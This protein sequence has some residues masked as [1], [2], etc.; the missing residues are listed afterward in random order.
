MNITYLD[1]SATTKPCKSAVEYVN[2]MLIDNWGNPSSLHTLG[3]DAE[4]EITAARQ[5][6][7][8]FLRCDERE[9][10]FTPS[11][12]I[13]NNI[14]IKGA[15][16]AKRRLGNTIVT[17]EIEHPSVY[18][19][20]SSLEEEG[21]NVIRLKP[22]NGNITVEQ[23]KNAITS[24]TILVSMMMVNNETGAILPVDKVSKIIA[25]A[26]SPALFH[27]DAVQAFGKIPI[28]LKTLGAQLVTVSGHKIHAPKGVA[29]LYISQKTRIAPLIF[30][31]GQERGVCPGTESC[32]IPAMGAAIKEIGSISE[33]YKK[34]DG[35][36]RHLIEQVEKLDRVYV[37]SN[38]DCLPYVVNISVEGIKSETLLHF[39]A[40]QGIYVSSG[41]A[42]SKGKKSRVLLSFGI[43]T[44]RVDSALR[45]SFSR[46]NDESDVDKLIT[47][48]K[49]AVSMF[50][51]GR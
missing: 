35:L 4:K 5:T 10:Y 46:Y 45:I 26:K 34:I 42:C 48:L 13:A 6:L 30:G 36:R 49:T 9:I 21:F 28:N 37:N 31:G 8:D 22:E 16:K 39:L 14:A 51:R 18:E 50:R 7:A 47:A 32:L 2:K 12:T 43:P 11:G 41:S 29:A 15:V 1:N 44:N 3:I 38:D 23:I 40:E 27:V 17:T 24:D 25:D 33:N 19:T 20:I